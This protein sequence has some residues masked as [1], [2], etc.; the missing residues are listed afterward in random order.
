MGNVGLRWQNMKTSFGVEKLG[1]KIWNVEQIKNHGRE[2]Y[3]KCILLQNIL[4]AL[5][6]RKLLCQRLAS[7]DSFLWQT[8]I[9]CW[10]FANLIAFTCFEAKTGWQQLT[11]TIQNWWVEIEIGH[12]YCLI[13]GKSCLAQEKYPIRSLPDNVPK[14]RNIW[15]SLKKEQP[16][17][18]HWKIEHNFKRLNNK[19]LLESWGRFSKYK[20]KQ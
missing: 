8:L 9:Y 11:K 7:C 1:V 10:R 17:K 3:R 12:W 14:R 16:N 20:I 18:H 6:S 2:L 19:M 4:W 5:E 13:G 15:S